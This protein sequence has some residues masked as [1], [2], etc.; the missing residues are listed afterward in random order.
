MGLRLGLFYRDTSISSM[1]HVFTVSLLIYLWWHYDKPT[2][3]AIVS[4]PKHSIEA[5]T[6][7]FRHLK[8]FT[9]IR[10]KNGCGI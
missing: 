9:T 4:T 7:H 8:L 10:E 6:S 1:Q 5:N 3:S 2:A